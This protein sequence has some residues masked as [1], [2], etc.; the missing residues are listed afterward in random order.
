ML[1]VSVSLTAGE[2]HYSS[3]SVYIYDHSLQVCLKPTDMSGVLSQSL[4]LCMMVKQSQARPLPPKKTLTHTYHSFVMK[5]KKGGSFI[6]VTR[7][8]KSH[9][10]AEPCFPLIWKAALIAARDQSRL[11]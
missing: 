11:D 2:Q 1:S 5:E 10:K 9:S 7:I 6:L 3:H 4:P 8:A